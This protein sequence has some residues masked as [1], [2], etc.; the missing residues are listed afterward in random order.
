MGGGCVPAMYI[1]GVPINRSNRTDSLDDFVTVLNIEG[2]EVYRGPSTQI[3]HIYDPSGCGLVLVW[4]RGGHGGGE[5]DTP[6]RWLKLAV[7]LATIGLVL[8]VTR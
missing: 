2:I 5:T 4:T 8:L 3:G 6:N 1:D 7:T